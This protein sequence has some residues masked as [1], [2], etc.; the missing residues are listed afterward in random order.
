M[1]A[2]PKYGRW[3]DA[4]I[5]QARLLEWSASYIGRR[6][7]GT[8]F[9]DMNMSH[10]ARNRRDPNMLY[11]LTMRALSQGEPTYVSE[12]ACD[13][14]DVARETF[15][16]EPALGSD[17]W[18]PHGFALLARPIFIHDAPV[19]T[20]SPWR[21]T[22][23]DIP[24]R[25]ISWTS[26]YSEDRSIGAFWVAYY[27]DVDD[28]VARAEELGMDIGRAAVHV[29]AMRREMPLSMMHLFEWTWGTVPG[30]LPSELGPVDGETAEETH[31]RAREQTAL[32]QTMWR[33]GS[34]FV[35]AAERLPRG[36][37]RDVKRRGID[38]EHV[39]VIRLRRRKAGDGEATSGRLTVQHPVRGYWGT[40]HRREG[41][42]QVWVD[43]YIRGDDS[44]PWKDSSLRAYE[45]NR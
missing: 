44:L 12:H 40:R 9:G 2:N 19:T 17:V 23:G 28:E 39:N 27:V 32:A 20:D 3:E 42:R 6:F 14:I 38:H 4:M 30:D 45:F 37:R 18:T 15:Q 43:Q 11:A 10:I 31:L 24:I 5:G 33:I 29:E 36:I 26:V 21:S 22:T 16:P 41:P 13:L 8:L 1:N 34:Q 25:A 7:L 35:P